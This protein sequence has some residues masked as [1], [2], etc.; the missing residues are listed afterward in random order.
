MATL[1]SLTRSGARERSSNFRPRLECLERRDVPGETLAAVMG[2]LIWGGLIP[3]EEQAAFESQP[4]LEAPGADHSVHV[5]LL[6]P[7]RAT[8][9]LKRHVIHRADRSG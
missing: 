9:P 3:V 1:K 7:V 8:F 4:S 5:D 2:V 6:V